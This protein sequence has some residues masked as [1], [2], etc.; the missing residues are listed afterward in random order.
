MNFVTSRPTGPLGKGTV[1]II[2]GDEAGMRV[3]IAHQM[4]RMAFIHGDTQ[5]YIG[6]MPIDEQRVKVPSIEHFRIIGSVVRQ[7][8][9]FEAILET[10]LIPQDAVNKYEELLRA[11]DWKFVEEMPGGSVGFSDG[12]RIA[13][14]TYCQEATDS[15]LNLMANQFGDLTSLHLTIDKQVQPCKPRMMP[16]FDHFRFVPTLETPPEARLLQNQ[17]SSGAS[18]Q[19]GSRHFSSSA[20]IFTEIPV[21]NIVTAYHNQLTRLGWRKISETVDAHSALSIW[22]FTEDN[23]SWDGQLVLPA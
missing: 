3:F 22:Q 20:S 18:G 8:G 13:S 1:E 4:G 19:M 6:Q 16:H 7:N 12:L 9:T 2:G 15:V 14:R 11:A 23:S 17:S 5:I 21:P 10:A